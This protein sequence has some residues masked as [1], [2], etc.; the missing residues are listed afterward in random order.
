MDSKYL[1]NI[2]FCNDF[3]II[4]KTI[5]KVLKRSDIASGKEL[6]MDDLD[7]E[8]AWMQRGADSND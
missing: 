3:I 2:T 7:K 8:R 1:K 6:I 5:G 4:I